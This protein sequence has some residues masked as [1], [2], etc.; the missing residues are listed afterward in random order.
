M[1]RP[2]A[3]A[4]RSVV[5]QAGF[6]VVRYREPDEAD[7]LRKA[8]H[9]VLELRA[10]ADSEEARFLEFSAARFA[11]SK[12]QLFQDLFVQYV[13][14]E[15][16]N[17]FFVEFGATNGVNLSN[18]HML[19]KH[20]GWRGILSEPARTWHDA[21]KRNRSCTIDTRCVWDKT[22]EELTFNETRDPELS[23]ID[24]FSRKDFHAPSRSG[25]EHYRVATIALDDLLAAHQAPR[26]IDYLS[27]DTEGSELKIL[28]AVDF[29]KHHIKVIT[30][31]HNNT[32]DREAI[33]ALLTAQGFERKL[34]TLS[35][36]DDWYVAKS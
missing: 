25:G 1:I 13:L 19:E 27:V 26:D 11:R 6:D 24:A 34:E 4:V 16:K 32:P 3:N 29:S 17:G 21:L 18:T 7:R 20:Y 22:G 12:S 35:Q 8:M 28:S 9:A 15:K 31:E 2:I 36:W 14:G 30:V 5:R 33:Y 23:T 10:L